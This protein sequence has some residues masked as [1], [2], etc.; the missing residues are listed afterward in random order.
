[1]GPVWSQWLGA[2][3]LPPP[4]G[5]LP[6]F[7]QW[8]TAH[9]D[10]SPGLSPS[11]VTFDLCSPSLLLLLLLCADPPVSGDPAP[12]SGG[13]AAAAAER[14]RNSFFRSNCQSSVIAPAPPRAVPKRLEELRSAAV[15][16]NGMQFQLSDPAAIPGP[17]PNRRL[18]NHNHAAMPCPPPPPPR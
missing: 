18:G 11:A 2:A 5:C 13:G 16:A 17:P 14:G 6:W 15:S 7:H 4:G 10:S 8:L 3:L 1:M 12:L 9:L